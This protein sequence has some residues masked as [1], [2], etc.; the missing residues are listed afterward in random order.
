[1]WQGKGTGIHPVSYQSWTNDNFHQIRNDIEQLIVR[2]EN[3]LMY[4]R[5]GRSYSVFRQKCIIGSFFFPYN[6]HI[7]DLHQLS[8][9]KMQPFYQKRTEACSVVLLSDLGNPQWIVLNCNKP[10]LSDIACVF[11]KK[12]KN[13]Q[14]NVRLQREIC[15]HQIFHKES[16]F[17]L[18]SFENTSSLQNPSQSSMSIFKLLIRA[19]GDNLRGFLDINPKNI[20]QI[21]MVIYKYELQTLEKRSVKPSNAPNFYISQD[22]LHLVKMQGEI[23]FRCRS[24]NFVSKGF[25]CDSVNH[26]NDQNKGSS[27]DEHFCNCGNQLCKKTCH[28]NRCNCSPLFYKS[29]HNICSTYIKDTKG[30]NVFSEKMLHCGNGKQIPE[31]LKDDLVP[32]CES[33]EDE[34]ILQYLLMNNTHSVCPHTEDIPC[35]YGHPKCYHVSRVC[36]YRLNKE[37][38][39]IPC[40][41]GSHLQ[42]CSE[43]ECNKEY[44]CPQYYCIPWGYVCD[45][46]W[47]CPDG[48]DE[49]TT[50]CNDH[51]KCNAMFSCYKSQTCIH[52]NDICDG[53]ND[54]ILGD[55]EALCSL[56]DVKCPA[57]CQCLLYALY[58]AHTSLTLSD[59]QGLPHISYFIINSTLSTISLLYDYSEKYVVLEFAHNQI[60]EICGEPISLC[61]ALYSINFGSNDIQFLSR[62]CF[63]NLQQLHIINLQSNQIGMME[64]NSFQNLRNTYLIDLSKNKLTKLGQDTFVNLTKLS[65]LL[66]H[67]NNFKMLSISMKIEAHLKVVVTT[68]F[69]VCCLLSK[70]TQ[71]RSPRS[72]LK[73]CS[74]VLPK[75]HMNIIFFTVFFL[76]FFLNFTSLLVNINLLRKREKKTFTMVIIHVHGCNMLCG[77]YFFFMTVVNIHLSGRFALYLDFSSVLLCNLILGC[78]TV[79]NILLPMLLLVSA[80]LR[81]KVVSDP[82]SS[83]FRMAFFVRKILGWSISCVF[84]VLITV[85]LLLNVFKKFSMNPFC[86]PLLTKELFS[87]AEVIRIILCLFQVVSLLSIVVFYIGLVNHLA[88]NLSPG[89]NLTKR[90]TRTT[91]SVFAEIA[92]DFACWIPS[93]L[94]FMSA[95]YF[96]EDPK[97]SLD[98]CTCCANQC[99]AAS[100]YVQFC[101]SQKLFCAHH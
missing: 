48:N 34:P 39:I 100:I 14:D 31:S 45:S 74:D 2:G 83:R 3:P 57:H 98:Y 54:C 50:M 30:K 86:F 10:A 84:L 12:D 95:A 82:L 29:I 71:C 81:F 8:V 42:D 1:M 76:T 52:V 49:M 43:F 13:L 27:S 23:L 41:T 15:S 67:I 88:K 47:D 58:C 69:T 6:R 26:C 28:K 53:L 46:K 21:S 94:V 5:P 101:N 11:D 92:C 32:D 56:Y 9:A 38:Y 16:C 61:K 60:T 25:V 93:N 97:T 87:F 35:R 17:D 22:S 99:H 89:A 62:S 91:T 78:V 90:L 51:K 55:D 20:S 65:Y 36:I 96:M 66:L 75:S 33:Q 7:A 73:W 70:E 77:L 40:R 59:F 19:V 79:Y 64:S 4:M 72:W 68:T 37:N 44:K 80:L 18:V 85:F 63:S 24:G